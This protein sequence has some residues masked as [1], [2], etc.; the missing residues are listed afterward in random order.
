[1]SKLT[2]I[3]RRWLRRTRK[4]PTYYPTLASPK[5]QLAV[6]FLIKNGLVTEDR[7]GWL[8]I[9][10]LGEK[11]LKTKSAPAARVVEDNNKIFY[12]AYGSNLNVEAMARRCPGAKKLGPLSLDDGTLVFRGVA[13]AV[14]EQGSIIH[15]GLWKISRRHE[16]TLDQYE[17]APRLYAK[18][19]L[20][21]L[22]NKQEVQCLYYQ[23]TMSVGVM[24]PGDMYLDCIA[25]GYR[26]FGLPL[27]ALDAALMRSWEDKKVTP[28]L[29][30]RRARRGD[31][32]AKR[33][34]GADE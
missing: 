20:K 5:S 9:T 33:T 32:L 4:G 27:E 6:S 15:G 24:P 25:Q 26:D 14:Y 18:R 11:V 13:D 8:H 31:R 22:V 30:Q 1:M 12:W 7:R 29:E 19:Y 3:Q 2:E 28:H 10:G 17:G 21:L 23:M 34:Y 16:A